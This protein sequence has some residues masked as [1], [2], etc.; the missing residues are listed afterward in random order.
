MIR[1]PLLVPSYV[2]YD[3]KK[4]AVAIDGSY[5]HLISLVFTSTDIILAPIKSRTVAFCYRLTRGVL[6]N[7][8]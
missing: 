3:F 5:A 2:R 7:D 8:N 1:S 4:L 6:E